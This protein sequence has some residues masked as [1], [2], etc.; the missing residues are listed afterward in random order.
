MIGDTLRAVFLTV[1]GSNLKA[2]SLN[3][4]PGEAWVRWEW[5]ESQSR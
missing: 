2:A 5:G 1:Y 3:Y 4:T